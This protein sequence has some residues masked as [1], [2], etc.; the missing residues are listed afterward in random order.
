MRPDRDMYINVLPEKDI[1]G[2]GFRAIDFADCSKIPFPF[3]SIW[4][5]HKL[6]PYD[7]GS[8][9]HY[10][11]TMNSITGEYVKVFRK[12]RNTDSDEAFNATGQGKGLSNLDVKK[13][14]RLYDCG[15]Q[16]FIVVNHYKH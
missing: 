9:M 3:C 13:I 1:E 12:K 16:K 11:H 8:I 15:K 2:Y 10:S 5:T 7:F 4:D 14:Q 6:G